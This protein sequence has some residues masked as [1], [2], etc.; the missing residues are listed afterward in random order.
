MWMKY[1]YR[2]GRTLGLSAYQ[3][4][5]MVRMGAVMKIMDRLAVKEELGND[6]R[7]GGT[8]VVRVERTVGHGVGVSVT[9]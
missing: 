6:A 5:E 9:L 1:F 7:G 8:G 3:M 4:M 2:E